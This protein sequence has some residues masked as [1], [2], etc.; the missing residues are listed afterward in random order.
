MLSCC[1]GCGT[2]NI[3]PDAYY[4]RNAHY[5]CQNCGELMTIDLVKT[6]RANYCPNCG[7]KQWWNKEEV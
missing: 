2:T 7:Q 5:Y 4:E 3:T 6:K 1:A